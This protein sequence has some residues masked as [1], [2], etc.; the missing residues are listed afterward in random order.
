MHT[1]PVTDWQAWHAPY[2]DPGSPLS[3]RLAAVQEQIR[4]ALDRAPAGPLRLLSLCAGQ[5]LDVLPV[6][7]DHP[8]GADVQGRLVELDPGNCAVASVAAPEG[9]EVR[10]ADAG[11]TDAAEGVAPV[12]LLLLCGIFGN[13]SD[14]DV[15][16]TVAAV[17]S[18]CTA[19]ATVVWTRHTHPPDLTPAIRA[20][21]AAAGVEEA[22]FVAEERPGWAVG[23]G[24]LRGAPVPLTPGQ[25]LFSFTQRPPGG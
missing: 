4:H 19:G 5:G 22:A 16:R 14:E 10:C 24:V 2:D 20:W 7:A 8:R 15:E 23:A 25:R 18:L 21:L 13:T 11:T 1:A 12:D 17:P 9:V 3:Q 6:L